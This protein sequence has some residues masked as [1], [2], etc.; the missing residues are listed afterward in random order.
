MPITHIPLQAFCAG[1]T[2][3]F[4]P[5]NAGGG[6]GGTRASIG[7]QL[8]FPSPLTFTR[9]LPSPPSPQHPSL[10]HK[11]PETRWAPQCTLTGSCPVRPRHTNAR[12]S[13]R[14][15]GGGLAPLARLQPGQGG[16]GGPD[17]APGGP[18][19]G[20]VGEERSRLSPAAG[21]W[22]WLAGAAL[23]S[24]LLSFHLER[25]GW[26]GGGEKEKEEKKPQQLNQKE[27]LWF[28]LPL[29]S[30]VC[31]PIPPRFGGASTASSSA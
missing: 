20:A 5:T 11:D 18:R 13:P 8:E 22:A 7:V 10:P 17:P 26:G 4:P 14:T 1:P 2:H 28:S 30:F 27:S 19:R 31:F 15:E 16:P 23:L 12:W 9:A 25:R 6:V 24:P 3:P 29:G 21:I